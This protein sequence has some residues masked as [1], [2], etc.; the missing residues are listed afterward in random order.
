MCV[1]ILTCEIRI[2][3]K[4]IYLILQTK[5]IYAW[6]ICLIVGNTLAVV[7]FAWAAPPLGMVNS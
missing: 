7:I 1:V 2:E 4:Y 5:S 6:L 3:M